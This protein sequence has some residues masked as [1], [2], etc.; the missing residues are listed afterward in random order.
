MWLRQNISLTT[1]TNIRQKIHII[2]KLIIEE[3]TLVISRSRGV[4][5]L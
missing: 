2:I 3:L 1:K 5:L 4:V